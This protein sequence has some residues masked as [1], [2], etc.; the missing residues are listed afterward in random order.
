MIRKPAVAGMFYDIRKDGLIQS[1]ESCFKSGLGPGR[2]PE[3]NKDGPHNIIG[4]VCPHAGIMYSG[5]AAAHSY[6]A[7][8]EDGLPDAA[9]IL[10]PNH[11]GIGAAVAVSADEYWQTPLG[12]V[13]IDQ[14][15]AAAIIEFSH[16]A[17][18]DNAAH[19]HEH[20]LEVQLPFLQYIFGSSISIVPIAISH[21]QESDVLLLVEDL[22]IAISEAVKGR[23]AVIIAS[24][25]FS[26][27]V[28]K[29]LAQAKDSIAIGRI[30]ALD[31]EG[32]VR[33]VYGEDISMCGVAGTAVMVE[34]CRKMGASTAQ[35]LAYYTSGDVTGDMGQVVGYGAIAI[36]NSPKPA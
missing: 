19:I 31:A 10:G 34:T 11:R 20:S 12:D 14:E 28:P 8:A 27:Y 32:L 16:Y 17:K 9:V 29:S 24:T 2:I 26:H 18:R 25:D 21:L 1:I 3:V 33:V 5:Y 7:L 36:F 35:K 15:T 6:L 30:L 4:L 13:R 22:S 23:N